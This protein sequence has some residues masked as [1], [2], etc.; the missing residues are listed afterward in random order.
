[1]TARAHPSAKAALLAGTLLMACAAAPDPQ[2]LTA[3]DQ[4]IAATDAA[5]LALR[6]LDRGRYTR[7]DSLFGDQD[8]A[9]R[10]RFAQP[11]RP[12]AAQPLASQWIAL[13]HAAAM[14]ADHERVLGELLA[15]AERLR[16]LRSDIAQGAVAPRAAA[17]LIAAE[18]QR[19]AAVM[20]A[21]HAVMD[22]YR[23]LQRAWD[24]RDTV[25][26]LLATQHLP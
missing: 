17:P 1:M 15:S 6:E 4:L 8:S 23:I 3:V 5:S 7:A 11:L 20:D 18:Q 21:A 16:A 9:L 25:R 26:T 24:R 22:N 19:H 2:Q 14:G 10:A 13:R 12:E